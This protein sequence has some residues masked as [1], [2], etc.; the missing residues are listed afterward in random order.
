MMTSY[1]GESRGTNAVGAVLSEAPV[2]PPRLHE[3]TQCYCPVCETAV[4]D[5]LP[6]GVV[7]KRSRARCPDC[8]VLERHRLMVLY[9]RGHTP[10][11]DGA[12]RRVL[13]VAPEPAIAAIL[14]A[15]PNVDYLSAD[16]SGENVMVRMDLTDIDYAD[17][18]FDAIVCSHVLEHIPEDA[19]AMREMFRVLSPGGVAVVQVP[20]YGQTTYEDFSIT[21]EADR[22]AAFGQ[23]DHVRKYGLDLARRLAGAGFY[24][25][26]IRAPADQ[27]LCRRLGLSKTPVFDC[28]KPNVGEPRP[29]HR[30]VLPVAPRA[31]RATEAS[32]SHAPRSS[33]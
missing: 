19:K 28:R 30:A 24:V 9:L 23:R 25:R 22:L 21:S 14:K 31:S 17:G 1:L 27:Q 5:F 3:K 11:F 29:G 7:A 20:I 26:E 6:G 18:T 12:P 8:G 4:D 16:L 10:L 2:E 13:H 15:L 32:V 33:D